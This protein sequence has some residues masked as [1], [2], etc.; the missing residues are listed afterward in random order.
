LGTKLFDCV[1]N[2]KA[3]SLQVEYVTGGYNLSYIGRTVKASVHTDRAAELSKFIKKRADSSEQKDIIANISGLVVDIKCNE[4]DLVTKGQPII[5][6]EAMKMEN[7]LYAPF[8]GKIVK[9]HAKKGANTSNGEI[10]I[11]IE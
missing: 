5:I 3:Y 7:I 1:I 9:I 4:G 2:E 11:E 8:D 6:L 10:L